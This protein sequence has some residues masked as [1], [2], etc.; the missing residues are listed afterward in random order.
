M[1]VMSWNLRSLRD[2]NDAAVAVVRAI[3]PD[4]LLVQEAPRHPGASRRIA[5]FAGRCGLS[6]GGR[7]RWVAGTTVLTRPGSATG[8]TRDHR[9]PVQGRIGRSANPRGYSTVR[10]AAAGT[11]FL[12]AS[13]H[14][15]LIPA[16]RERHVA[17]IITGLKGMAGSAPIVVGGDLNESSEAAAWLRLAGE[18]PQ[19]SRDEPTF[20]SRRPRAHIDGIFADPGWRAGE[21]A[22]PELRVVDLEA[23]TDHRPLW[24]DLVRD[25]SST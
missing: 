8:P 11:E 2:D 15:S 19:V 10:V 12:A 3:D 18:F 25:S 1:R 5:R 7:T 20:P 9:L 16:E 13:I 23:A 21:A 14:L 4:V 24:V 6:W 17:L 22:T